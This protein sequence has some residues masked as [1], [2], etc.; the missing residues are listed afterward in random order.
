MNVHPAILEDTRTGFEQQLS[1]VRGFAL[2]IDIDVIDWERTPGKTISAAIALESD[3]GDAGLH[4][5][6]M[7]D[8]PADTV[9][10][11]ISDARVRTVIVNLE[12]ADDVWLLLKRISAEGKLAGISVNPETGIETVRQ[13]YEQAGLIQVMTIEPG[14]QGNP[15]M[16]ER[17][18]LLRDVREDGYTGLLGV[19]GHITPDTIAAA[20]AAGASRFSVGSAILKAP[21]PEAVYMS[22]V[23][24]VS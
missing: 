14:V 9:A 11:L 3:F 24:K 8:R 16:E 1:R 22:L 15:F 12:S 21:D 2:D 10:T 19:D 5:D 6:L 17:L 23:A 7:M 13:Y 4:F 18:Q 20:H